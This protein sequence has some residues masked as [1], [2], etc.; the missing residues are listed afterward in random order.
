MSLLL[1]NYARQGVRAGPA[2]PPL[3]GDGWVRYDNFDSY[4]V[5]QQVSGGFSLTKASTEQVF[6][7]S[8]SAKMEIVNGTDGWGTWGFAFGFPGVVTRGMTLRARF[9]QY[10]PDV[11]D[12]PAVTQPGNSLKWF[13]FNPRTS[14]GSYSGGAIDWQMNNTTS[15]NGIGVSPAVPANWSFEGAGNPQY[16]YPLGQSPNLPFVRHVWECF[17]VAITLDNV[18]VANGGLAEMRMW[19]NGNVYGHITNARNLVN[20]TDQIGGFGN[21][22]MWIHTFY[23]S[24]A[25][26]NF[27]SYIDELLITTKTPTSL[28]ANGVPYMGT[29]V[30]DPMEA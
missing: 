27:F 8:K 10:L 11:A 30:F 23:N 3:V 6:T 28:D 13:R 15:Y 9:W 22:G 26:G 20:A 14:T 25:F 29:E 7:G 4:A 12:F 5:G 1:M 17:E 24:L 19:K 21:T 16:F 18:S 2:T